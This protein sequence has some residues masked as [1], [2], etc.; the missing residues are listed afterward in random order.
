MGS[1]F[2]SRR[3][4]TGATPG[5]KAAAATIFV[6]FICT[7]SCI[8]EPEDTG[9]PSPPKIP[10]PLWVFCD[11]FWYEYD[12][13]GA[14]VYWK[15][16]SGNVHGAAINPSTGDIW[17]YSIGE[18]FSIFDPT[19]EFRRSLFYGGYVSGPAFD[20]K[21]EIV[22]IYQCR[23]DEKSFLR[24]LNYKGE[25]IE[26]KG[27]SE[28]I[29]AIDVYEAEGELWGTT[30]SGIRKYTTRGGLV[31]RKAVSEL[32]YE[33]EVYRLFV[34]QTDGGVW[35]AGQGAPYFI[36][37]DRS[38]ERVRTIYV[39]GKIL[40]V[41]RKSGYVLAT[42]EAEPDVWYLELFDKSG[43]SL[44]RRGTAEIPYGEGLVADFDG[45]C[46]YT[47]VASGEKDELL[48][49]KYNEKGEHV[50]EDVTVREDRTASSLA[51]WNG[52]YPYQ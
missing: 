30:G 50:V 36:K 9:R 16:Y 38:G 17:T 33:Y 20:T 22:W 15:W 42:V 10:H 29:Y 3:E 44:W 41:G 31:F 43:K 21:E 6:A 51:M 34:D 19:G 13:N 25:I 4:G 39:T 11:N 14:K 28:F 49:G 1:I 5:F 37:V 48:L 47:R 40:D 2:R 45:S 23:P 26:T 52:P 12:Q 46:W 8:F 27:I 18:S 32:G 7:V 24:V 35:L